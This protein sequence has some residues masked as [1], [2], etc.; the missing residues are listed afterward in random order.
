[1]KKETLLALSGAALLTGCGDNTETETVRVV[2]KDPTPAQIQAAVDKALQDLNREDEELKS[3]LAQIQKTEPDVVG[4]RYAFENGEKVLKIAMKDDEKLSGLIEYT[5]PIATGSLMGYTG[6]AL[7]NK[8]TSYTH[9]G[10]SGRG[11]CD[12]DDLLEG[13]D[14]CFENK[15]HNTTGGSTFIYF[16]T[17][18]SYHYDDFDYYRTTV[19]KDRKVYTQKASKKS[20]SDRAKTI[21]SNAKKSVNNGVNSSYK[22]NSNYKSDSTYKSNSSIKS[23][24]T[25][26]YKSKTESKPKASLSQSRQAFS[27]KRSTSRSSSMSFGSSSRSSW[28]G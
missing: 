16:R 22:S 7:A 13:D 5:V 18:P 28:G 25:Q 10:F 24:T 26:S 27:T 9:E 2:Y 3:F 12:L 14:D 17:Y 19:R 23:T 11:D 6:A 8:L 4:A 21:K 20:A 15:R 1:M